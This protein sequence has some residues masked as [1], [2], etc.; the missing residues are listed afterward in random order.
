MLLSHFITNLLS[1]SPSLS[2]YL[3]PHPSDQVSERPHAST[4]ALQCSEENEVKTSLDHSIS[5]NVT[6]EAV[7]DIKSLF[8]V[9]C[10]CY[11]P[12]WIER[13]ESCLEWIESGV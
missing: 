2:L 6:D 12:E 11:G 8:V 10:F 5:D 9:A 1:M 3:S 13:R 4:T 7:L